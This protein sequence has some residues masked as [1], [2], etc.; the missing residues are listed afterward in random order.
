MYMDNPSDFTEH[1]EYTPLVIACMCRD[2][3]LAEDLIKE[4]ADVNLCPLE[5]TPERKV[6]PLYY[7][8]AAQDAEI[9][10]LLLNS[11]ADVN[12]NKGRSQYI[13]IQEPIGASYSIFHIPRP[14]FTTY[15]VSC[16]RP[17]A[18]IPTLVE[19]YLAAG[20]KLNSTPWGPCLFYGRGK[21]Y[22]ADSLSLCNL[23]D[24]PM[25]PFFK[26]DAAILLLQ[27][28][29]DP[30]L[31]RLRDVWSQFSL[32]SGFKMSDGCLSSD[33]MLKTFLGA[34]YHI[35]LDDRND[36]FMYEKAL[37]HYDINID[38]PLSLKQLCRSQI[39]TQLR[40]VLNDTT[41]FPSI[42]QLPIPSSLK[43]FL[44]LHDI[45]DLNNSSINCSIPH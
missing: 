1:K 12:G 33:A 21:V 43:T 23:R 35:T 45:I 27:H 41:I 38:E 7:A 14:Y 44:K 2:L 18:R 37:R 15:S 32:H 39:R 42:E 36:L 9:V 13:D 22:M 5:S 4:G 40:T 11:G 28:G 3:K 8:T 34:G 6:P 17:L 19:L 26:C 16:E 24:V 10:R 25:T 29:V 20:V 31:Y 30:N